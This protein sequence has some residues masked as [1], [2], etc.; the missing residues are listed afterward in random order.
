MTRSPVK[1]DPEKLAAARLVVASGAT[2]RE[3]AERLGLSY[4]ATRKRAFRE[5]WVSGQRIAREAEKKITQQ[6]TQVATS[7]RVERGERYTALLAQAAER[8]AQR[9]AEL[10]PE[11]LIS[12]AAGIERMDKVSRRTL[13]LDTD[14]AD[15]NAVNIALLGT[16]SD[17]P[18]E[19]SKRIE[20]SNESFTSSR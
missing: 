5:G 17:L 6:A 20:A 10:D 15:V 3:T 13:G 19:R 7:S 12:K 2:I 8:F 14:N 9:A 16:Y 18:S 11:T 1:L 4:E